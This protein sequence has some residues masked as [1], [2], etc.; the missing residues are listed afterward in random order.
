MYL[1]DLEIL[2]HDISKLG[3][4]VL[5][6]LFILF[7]SLLNTSPQDDHN[8]QQTRHNSNVFPQHNRFSLLRSK[9]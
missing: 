5:L 7:Q 4:N 9:S 8:L 6:G 2:G 1:K 3:K